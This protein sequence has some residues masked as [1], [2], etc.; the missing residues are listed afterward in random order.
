MTTST[1]ASPKELATKIKETCARL[2][3]SYEVRGSILTITKRIKPGDNNDFARA[4]GEYYDILSILPTTSHGSIWGTD[5][6]GIGAMSA[7]NTGRFVMNKSGGSV[8]V[9]NALK[10]A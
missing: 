10:K 9:L 3:W 6:S 5:G 1:K 8:R 7:M 2:N 4:D